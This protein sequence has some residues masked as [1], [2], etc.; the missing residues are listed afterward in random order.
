MTTLI[1]SSVSA[2]EPLTTDSRSAAGRQERRDA[3]RPS[4]A[5]APTDREDHEVVG[6]P[7]RP[8]RLSGRP[9]PA[10]RRPA[11]ALVAAGRR[12]PCR[13]LR[14]VARRVTGSVRATSAGQR[15]APRARRRRP[16][17]AGPP[18]ALRLRLGSRPVRRR[19]DAALARPR[20][21]APQLLATRQLDRG[22]VAEDEP[23]R[24]PVE[25]EL[26]RAAGSRGSAGS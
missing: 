14:G 17:P 21:R 11:V 9:S 5:G 16:R 6:V 25:A 26:A 2:L 12:D 23:D 10:G 18:S 24:R 3:A 8:G 19:R 22:A 1:R 4:A 13:R 15:R 7:G 20:P